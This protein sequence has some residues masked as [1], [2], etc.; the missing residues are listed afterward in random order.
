MRLSLNRTPVSD[1]PSIQKKTQRLA[2]ASSTRSRRNRDTL[3]LPSVAKAAAGSSCL[4]SA[5]AARKATLRFVNRTILARVSVKSGT[6]S[7]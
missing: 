4:T 6:C 2:A 1:V 7:T 5:H 3:D